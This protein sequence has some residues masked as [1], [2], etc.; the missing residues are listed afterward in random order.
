[1]KVWIEEIFGIT[2]T[3]TQICEDICHKRHEIKMGQIHYEN[4]RILLS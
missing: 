3:T 2:T 4:R 1:V